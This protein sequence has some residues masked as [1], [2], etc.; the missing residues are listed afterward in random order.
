MKEMKIASGST[1]NEG[2]TTTPS[3][4][5]EGVKSDGKGGKSS[6]RKSE[7]CHNFLGFPNPSTTTAV[8]PSPLTM[9]S[10]LLPVPEA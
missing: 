7:G 9:G 3:R 2:K 4:N 1:A 5:G 8:P 10:V 6:K